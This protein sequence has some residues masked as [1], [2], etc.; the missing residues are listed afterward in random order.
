MLL[1][2]AAG[3]E[4]GAFCAT[5]AGLSDEAAGGL[6]SEP[7]QPDIEHTASR[8]AQVQTVRDMINSSGK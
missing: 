6:L 5:V 2:A 8:Q 3:A 7:P 1:G 4:E